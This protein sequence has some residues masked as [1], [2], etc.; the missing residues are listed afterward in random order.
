MA[1]ISKQKR[2]TTTTLLNA[3]IPNKLQMLQVKRNESRGE[4][5]PHTSVA[6]LV[7]EAIINLLKKEKIC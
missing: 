4:N 6:D 7:N 3:D 2:I 5:T 1:N